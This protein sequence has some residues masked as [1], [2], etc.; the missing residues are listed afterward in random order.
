MAQWNSILPEMYLSKDPDLK[1]VVHSLRALNLYDKNSWVDLVNMGYAYL[2]DSEGARQFRIELARR[3]P[4]S[5]WAVQAAIQHWESTHQPPT[6]AQSGFT[7]WGLARVEFLKRLH[8]G[9]PD[10]DEATREYVQAALL[11][12]SRLREDEALLVAD[13][14]L[15][16]SHILR[17]DPRFQV[18]EI[19][20]HRRVRLDEVPGLL[21][22]AVQSL[23]SSF[24]DRR[25]GGQ[26]ES[27]NQQLIS[28]QL[29]AHSDLAE[30]WLQK[31]DIEKARIAARQAG[32]ELMRLVP[33]A[34]GPASR[35]S[36]FDIEQKLWLDLA[37]RVGIKAEPLHQVTELDWATV[38]RA[39]LGDFEATDLDGRHWSIHDWKGKVV[40]VNM[41]ATW[42]GPCRAEL[43]YL[44]KL[45]EEL[46][47]RADRLVIS[48]DV[49]SEDEL[50]RRLMR[51]Q[52]YT[53][54]VISSRRLADAIDFANGVPQNRI[55]DTQGRLL[56][57][58]VEGTGDAWVTR[59][60]ALMDRVQ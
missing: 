37:N 7:E 49:D 21:N 28:A 60:K 31:D 36:I 44:Q 29:R 15:R 5:S 17:F 51:E 22:D 32:A 52:G 39:P 54:S 57:E 12:E 26:A 38:E 43:P 27:V 23:Q 59:V 47:G 20:L 3:R 13:L 53:F 58:P 6:T 48:I 24:R 45:H 55:I 19:Y 50:A 14:A 11:Y 2:G 18:A 46:R 56:A 8:E 35:R 41:W 4:D 10:S 42:C 40:L 16:T 25:A 34:D 1:A 30:Y 33:A 9:K